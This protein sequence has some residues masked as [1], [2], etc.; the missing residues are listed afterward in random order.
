MLYSGKVPALAWQFVKKQEGMLIA[1]LHVCP[2]LSVFMGCHCYP[3]WMMPCLRRVTE[4]DSG[5]LGLEG[6]GCCIMVAVSAGS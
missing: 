2:D 5:V 6:M 3:S 4:G 1:T